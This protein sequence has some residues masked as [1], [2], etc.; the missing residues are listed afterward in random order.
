MEKLGVLGLRTAI[1]KVGDIE[2]A[3]KWYSY[4]FLMFFLLRQKL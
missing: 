1:Y 3:T 2:K 4:V